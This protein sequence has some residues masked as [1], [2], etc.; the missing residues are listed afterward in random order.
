[1]IDGE[2]GCVVVCDM[3]RRGGVGDGGDDCVVA[4]MMG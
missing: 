1:M 4:C 2:D 3:S